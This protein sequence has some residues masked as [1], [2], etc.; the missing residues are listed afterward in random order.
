MIG[1]SKVL[2]SGNRNEIIHSDRYITCT[3]NNMLEMILG[4]DVWD[5]SSQ[6]LSLSYRIN[7]S[8]NQLKFGVPGVTVICVHTQTTISFIRFEAIMDIF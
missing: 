6:N 8:I 3:F 1:Y 4:K 2:K 5:G 7:T